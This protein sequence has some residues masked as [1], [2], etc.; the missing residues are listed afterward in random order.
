MG[1]DHRDHAVKMPQCCLPVD[2]AERVVYEDKHA[3]M[4]QPKSP[5]HKP[6]KYRIIRQSIL[7]ANKKVR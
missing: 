3:R 7:C 4:P 5:L 2:L 6:G 1:T